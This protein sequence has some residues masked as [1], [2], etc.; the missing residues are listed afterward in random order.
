MSLQ[1]TLRASVFFEGFGVHSGR[2]VSVSIHPAPP[3]SGICFS[4]KDLGGGSKDVLIQASHQNVVNTQLAITLGKEGVTI[5]TVEHLLAALQGLG[6]DNAIIEVDGPEIPILDG[7]A[8]PF[9][10][11][12]SAIGI[13]SQPA[14]RNFLILQK[15]VELKLEGKWAFAEPASFFEIHGSIDWNHPAIGYQEF[16]YREGKTNFSELAFARTFGFLEEVEA[17]KKMG[18]A[19]GGSLENAVVLDQSRVLNP[20]GLR[21]SDEFIKHKVLDALGDFKLSG[22]SFC[23]RIRLHRAGHDLHYQLLK[24]IFK[25][26]SNYTVTDHLSS[27]VFAE[28][29]KEKED[30]NS[31]LSPGF[32]SPILAMQR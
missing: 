6:I 20:E 29:K 27:D 19:R 16:F 13:E 18:L 9:F 5:S 28:Q 32:A 4:R 11:A 25:S 15:K 2:P 26:P 22:F 8:L 3:Q 7:S 10:S 21:C 31:T 1:H 23:A 30:E 12:I 24:E 17:L 14:R